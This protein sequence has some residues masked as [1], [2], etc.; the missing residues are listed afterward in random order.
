M[1]EYVPRDSP[2]DRINI[3][4]FSLSSFLVQLSIFI[5]IILGFCY[6]SLL[7]IPGYMAMITPI[8]YEKEIVKKFSM[9]QKIEKEYLTKPLLDI[10]RPQLDEDLKNVTVTV[11]NTR[12]ENAYAL[13]GNQII[14]TQGLLE[15]SVYENEKLF[16]LAHELG[17]LKYRHPLKQIY[18][19]FLGKIFLAFVIDDNNILDLTANLTKLKFS[20]GDEKEADLFALQLLQKSRGDLTGS[21]NFFKRMKLKKTKWHGYFHSFLSTHPHTDERI[22]YLESRLKEIS[23]E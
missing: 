10:L 13:P 7:L 4:V 21:F 12:Q 6:I 2:D 5:F 18:S 8:E 9:T 16:V 22:Q 17:H 23:S 11:F 14:L 1:S 20:R 19:S 3:S 15:R